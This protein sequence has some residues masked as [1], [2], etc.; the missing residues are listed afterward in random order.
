MNDMG[1]STVEFVVVTAA[2]LVVAAALSALWNLLSEGSV[3]QH[4]IACASHLVAGGSL[5]MVGDVF[6]Y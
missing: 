4:A 2:F 6:L 5:G 1:Q 3:V